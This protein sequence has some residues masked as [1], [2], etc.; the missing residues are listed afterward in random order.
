MYLLQLAADTAA[1]VVNPELPGIVGTLLTYILG[2][3]AVV[4]LITQLLKKVSTTVSDLSPIVKQVVVM[5]LSVGITFLS[6]L[7]PG[8]DIPSDIT[9]WGPQ[10]IV[11]IVTSF[12]AFG[13][14]A[15]KKALGG[16][17]A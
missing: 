17:T 6:K 9:G 5:V 11:A 12:A 15:I 14:Y 13:W 1:A 3:G 7:V 10:T 2:S 8:L 16:R 4:A